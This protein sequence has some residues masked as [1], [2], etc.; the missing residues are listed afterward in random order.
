[1]IAYM[2]NLKCNAN[3]SIYKIETDSETQRTNLQLPNGKGKGEGQIRSMGIIDTN[4][5]K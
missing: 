4:N 1:M 3:E 5:H 2:W